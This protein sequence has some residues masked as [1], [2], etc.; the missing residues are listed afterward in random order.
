MKKIIIII[1]YIL[2]FTS[3][4]AQGMNEG[5]LFENTII[6]DNN[7]FNIGQL[8]DIQ[9]ILDGLSY[10]KELPESLRDY[11]VNDDLVFNYSQKYKFMYPIPDTDY[12]MGYVFYRQHELAAAKD[13]VKFLLNQHKSE[14]CAFKY[15]NLEQSLEGIYFSRELNSFLFDDLDMVFAVKYLIGRELK[16]THYNGFIEIED[17]K[18]YMTAFSDG[19]DSNL[20]NISPILDEAFY[21]YGYSLDVKVEKRF[22]DKMYII[23]RGEDLLSSIYWKNVFSYTKEYSNSGL[24]MYKSKEPSYVRGNFYYGDYITVLRPTYDLQSGYRN[25]KLGITYKYHMLP[26]IGYNFAE[27]KAGVMVGGYKNKY[28]I[29]L[30]Y[31]GLTLNLS[32]DDQRQYLKAKLNYVLKF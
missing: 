16:E 14:P 28:M 8:Y 17:D 22:D 26:Y 18:P 15:Y 23:F 11:S 6:V 12:R 10:N 2:I 4:M 29:N 7:I 31:R 24:G 19:I 5:L 25:I 21:S 27:N 1:I 32:T 20:N 3:G 9:R 13:S 30:Q